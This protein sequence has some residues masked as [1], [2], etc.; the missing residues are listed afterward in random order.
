[1]EFAARDP[2]AVVSVVSTPSEMNTLSGLIFV[3]ALPDTDNV[4]LVLFSVL[5]MT[6]TE[7]L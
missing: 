7:V 1:M 5:G 4:V 2:F 3:I 6:S